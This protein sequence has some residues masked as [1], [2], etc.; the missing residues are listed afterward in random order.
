MYVTVQAIAGYHIIVSANVN[1]V[2]K[3]LS[4][5]RSLSLLCN[6]HLNTA[7]SFKVREIFTHTLVIRKLACQ[8][9]V[10]II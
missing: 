6:Y 5:M 7:I 3:L 9:N 8:A 1:A 2:N 10:N 4:L